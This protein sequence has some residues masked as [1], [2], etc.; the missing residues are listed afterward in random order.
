VNLHYKAYFGTLESGLNTGGPHF[1]G[2]ICI[3]KD[4]LVP[5]SEY[6]GGHISGVN[7]HYKAYLVPYPEYWG[8][9]IS[10]VN[11]HTLVP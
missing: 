10:G 4:T 8:V 6:W 9:H 11:L 3:T 7:L 1:R 5:W 2:L